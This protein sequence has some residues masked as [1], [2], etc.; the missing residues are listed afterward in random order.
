[1]IERCKVCLTR[2][3]YSTK[4]VCDSCEYRFAPRGAVSQTW[5]WVNKAKERDDIKVERAV[6]ILTYGEAK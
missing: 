3:P 6:N 4:F 1:M 5:G 2:I